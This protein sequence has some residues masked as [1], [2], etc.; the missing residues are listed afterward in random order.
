MFLK[1]L[2]L[3]GFKSF[4]DTTKLDFEPGVTVV[5]G[6]NGSGKSNLVDAIAW[7]LGS[8]SPQAIRSGKMEDVIFQGS[9]KRSALGRA[10]VSLIL[11]NESGLIPLDFPEIVISRTLFKTGESEY[12]INGSQCRLL[13]VADLLSDGGMGKS[14]HTIV[15]QGEVDTVLNDRSEERRLIIEEA[16]G[17]LKYKKR[18]QVAEK[19]LLDTDADLSRLGDL[20]RE[21]ARQLE[22]LERQAEAAHKH[23]EMLDHLN[24]L[25][26]FV[27]GEEI[28]GRKQEKEFLSQ[29]HT[30][31]KNTETELRK[32]QVDLAESIKTEEAKLNTFSQDNSGE[33]LA[34]LESLKARTQAGLKDLQERVVKLGIETQV[35][36]DLRQANEEKEE[37]TQELKIILSQNKEYKES[38]KELQLELGNLEAIEKDLNQ[39]NAQL[40]VAEKLEAEVSAEL[41]KCEAE[42]LEKSGHDFSAEVIAH[43]TDLENKK[44]ERNRWFS[45]MEALKNSEDFITSVEN[46]YEAEILGNLVKPKPGYEQATV[47]ALGEAVKAILP[48]N[49]DDATQILEGLKEKGLMGLV[50]QS[51]EANTN[52]VS[53]E[54]NQYLLRPFVDID[55]SSSY[56]NTSN[57]ELL[58]ELLKGVLVVD[59]WEEAFKLHLDTGCVVVSKDGDKFSKTGWQL[60]NPNANVD[61]SLT[62]AIRKSSMAEA[63]ASL[64]E[65][66]GFIQATTRKLKDL[67]E[68]ERNS[69]VVQKT[70]QAQIKSGTVKLESTVIQKEELTDRQHELERQYQ[71]YT[72]GKIEE[73]ESLN[74][75]AEET[76]QSQK[77]IEI[78]LS[79][80]N[81][82][83]IL[84]Q[85]QI[86]EGPSQHFDKL[87]VIVALNSFFSNIE[88]Q[89]ESN[90][91]ALRE[92]RRTE[93]EESQLI[94]T[95]LEKD[96][97]EKESVDNRLAELRE[98]VTQVEINFAEV[99]AHLDNATT[100]LEKDLECTLEQAL[101]AVCPELEDGKTPAD[102]IEKIEHELR[103]IGPVNH[104]ALKEFETI[105]SRHSFLTEQ[106]QDIKDSRKELRHLI[107][108]V[109]M[110]MANAFESAFTDIAASF[111]KLFQIA[112]PGG[113]G[114]LSL[115]NPENLLETG[116]DIS[117]RPGDKSIKRLSLLSGG[118][119]SLVALTFLFS[120]IKCRPA[121]FCILD[122]VDAALDDINLCRFLDLVK[123]LISNT[124]LLIISH[125]KRTMEAGDYLYGISMISEGITKVISEKRSSV[126]KQTVSV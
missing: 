21:V 96:R 51:Y 88:S 74:K 31:L 14:Q 91:V 50:L 5:V 42:S 124:Q 61:T 87:E 44:I 70:L 53:S 54:H 109:D 16:A 105:K 8:Q 17:V 83:L 34:S 11:D 22:P 103:L 90:L 68:K 62:S 116:V 23:G 126:G 15:S 104:L 3:K 97:R 59:D 37:L 64:T 113:E 20:V 27:A 18:R 102:Y 65:L 43:K 56:S 36:S 47:V 57:H 28:K 94:A 95:T 110:E 92:S 81:Q 108:S 80:N 111:E 66:E 12:S 123:E 86:D 119:R 101:E 60:G 24:R 41:E 100:N 35:L 118:E 39:V 48:K 98:S 33:A 121:P 117:A 84:L 52:H 78:T 1:S 77:E 79:A 114:K 13:D 125:Q 25:R 71:M 32:H 7:V 9:Q 6:P 38:Q 93:S 89:I 73:L 115:S 49:L 10:E 63:K 82:K 72:S 85:Q 120:V 40:A 99:S 29:K 67:E 2:E 58:D 69:Q 112:F 19:R 26:L 45:K 76:I 106:V 30:E 107:R 46:P 75:R 55:T 122:E 4:A